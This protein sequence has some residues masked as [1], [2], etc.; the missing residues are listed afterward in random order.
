MPAR[1]DG[2]RRC[3]YCGS[4]AAQ[5]TS[6]ANAQTLTLN[7]AEQLF[8]VRYVNN[9]DGT[10]DTPDDGDATNDNDVYGIVERF[11]VPQT[12]AENY[13]VQ[14][15]PTIAATSYT[16]DP[17]TGLRFKHNEVN[18]TIW[19]DLVWTA[20]TPAD[21]A[22]NNT[23]T[24]YAIDYTDAAAINQHTMW[25]SLPNAR[26]PSDLGATTQYT[27]KGVTPGKQYTYRVFPEFGSHNI[28]RYD[29]RYGL[30][31]MED[32]ASKEADLPKPVQGLMVVPDPEN[33][34]TALQLTWN[35]LPDDPKGHP[36]EGYLV[37]VAND[38][39]NNG[40]LNTEAGGFDWLTLAIQDD[41]DTG[42]VDESRPWTVD[43]DTLMYV[44][45]GSDLATTETLAGGYVRWFHV[46]AI[47]D[48]NDGDTATGGSARNPADGEPVSPPSGGEVSPNASDEL[49]ALPKDGKT[50]PPEAPDA[51]SM[52]MSPPMPEDLT[53]EQASDNN[54][55][56][57]TDSGVFLTW[58]EPGED[59]GGI[60]AYV[61]QRKVGTGDWT[62]IARV[63]ARTSYSD[64]REYIDGEDLQYRVGSLGASS[65]P[66]SYTYPV[67]Y[68]THQ[69]MHAPNA[70]TGVTA[71]ADSATEVTVS[72]TTPTDNGGSPITGFKVMYKVT[73]AADDTYETDMVSDPMASMHTVMGLMPNTSYDFKVVATNAEG[74]GYASMMA[75]AMTMAGM[76]TAPSMVVATE[77]NE[78]AG[79]EP[80]PNPGVRVTWT[81]GEGAIGHLVLLF[82]SS[83]W[84]LADT[85]TMQDSGDTTFFNVAPGNY[86]AVVVAYDADT[87]IELT[88]SEPVSVGGS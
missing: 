78:T 75:M 36:V 14:D 41:T 16:A 49:T 19:L 31:A 10:N 3:G 83:D 45:D 43:K 44:Y 8:Q 68:P 69:A 47:T 58:N 5:W 23:P 4:T 33:P 79:G 77:V 24:G 26:R 27:H 67:T 29:Y 51:P 55:L 21:T 32:A 42:D 12:T 76:L 6:T 57:P 37:Q 71:T 61:V 65:V 25:K 72:W 81:D 30:P 87:N 1:L 70:P 18:P 80:L 82:D 50:A 40:T 38:R 85:A 60:N 22:N 64:D 15:L 46:I 52:T 56:E 53:S 88:I 34:Q 62:P 7:D 48:E 84:S 35:R 59:A 73:G 63:T 9:V 74:D 66:A 86:L 20:D 13:E 39:D 11:H 54:L 28:T 17:Q 2:S